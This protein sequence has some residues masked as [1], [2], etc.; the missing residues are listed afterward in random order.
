ML[1]LL[2]VAVSW[3][4]LHFDTWVGRVD[5]VAAYIPMYAF[6]GEELRN[7]NI[8]G[9]SPFQA[10][11]LPFAGD[12]QS[13]WAYLPVMVFYSILSP[14]AATKAMVV[15]NLALASVSTYIFARVLGLR[16]LGSLIAAVSFAFGATVY[17]STYCCTIWSQLSPWLPFGFL[18][19]E[20]GA[21][22]R[23]WSSRLGGWSLT[24]FAVSQMM[25]G[26][27]GQG[28]YNAALLLGAY[29]AYRTLIAP[30]DG[31]PPIRD[32]LQRLVVA[33]TAMLI[34]SL[35]LSAAGLLPRLEANRSTLLAGG[36]Y[37]SVIGA[38]DDAGLGETIRLLLDTSDRNMSRGYYA[39][40]VTL[41]LAMLSLFTARRRYAVPFF[42]ASSVVIV[43][44]APSNSPLRYLYDLLPRYR[45]LHEHAP[46][47]VF[48]LFFLLPAMLAG[49][50]SETIVPWLSRHRAVLIALL[51]AVT[52]YVGARY[53]EAR[54]GEVGSHAFRGAIAV[55][56]IVLAGIAL[57][58]AGRRRG[59]RWSGR[60][61]Q[62]APVLLLV[63]L[64]WEPTGR[65]LTE[66]GITARPTPPSR[67]AAIEATLSDTDLDGAG[68]FI[69]R[70]LDASGEPFRYFGYDAAGLQTSQPGGQVAY[71]QLR[72]DPH[73][74]S[75]LTGARA[76]RL[77]INDLQ[78][79]NPIQ[80]AIYTEYLVALNGGVRQDYHVANILISGFDSPLVNLLNARYIVV[81]RD[82]PP[83]RPDL[84]RLSQLHPTVFQNELIR[85]LE[86]QDS[87]PHAWI[88]HQVTEAPHDRMLNMLDSGQIDPRRMTL[89]EHGELPDLVMQLPAEEDRVS[90][91]SYDTDAMTLHAS[92]TGNGMLVVSEIFTPG[93]NAYVDGENIPIQEVNY[94]F[95][96]IPL[97]AGDHL[98]ELRYEPLALTIGL[99][100]TSVTLIGVGLVALLVA[101]TDGRRKYRRP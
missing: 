9:W 82:V 31:A 70:Q 85:V 61:I 6:L 92:S 86:N 94:L 29:L 59:W 91:V 41:G 72:L 76:T 51:P 64:L 84:L 77:R 13:G 44:L 62:L 95:R 87:F 46:S 52:V 79:Y 3:K 83:G 66:G 35:G 54:H 2:T 89:V 50:A 11:G 49:A 88:T 22:R 20:I 25:A 23:A 8:P 68:A 18:G 56:L 67:A 74:Y 1:M 15:F 101:A 97:P 71:Q 27:L 7:F 69:R 5:L 75:L 96:G 38:P 36:D 26:W 28:I 32:R 58:H 42:A 57:H 47:R 55:S 40:G 80:S 81:P 78:S 99:A 21:Q 53:L 100:V 4:A 10:S 98:V 73:Y 43:M 24:A 90:V 60:L 48:G 63:A 34:L 45:D 65:Q 30:P 37:E 12:P 33:G 17:H 14:V 39:G 19:I 93:W 16:P